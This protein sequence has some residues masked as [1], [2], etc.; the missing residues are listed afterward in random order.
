MR[1]SMRTRTMTK[2]K[3]NQTTISNKDIKD[4]TNVLILAKYGPEM[5]SFVIEYWNKTPEEREEVNEKARRFC[6]AVYE[7]ISLYFKSSESQKEAIVAEL[8]KLA[9]QQAVA[10][11][12]EILGINTPDISN[13]MKFENPYQYSEDR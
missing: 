6:E 8:T 4:I 7:V 1:K 11:L 12:H 10:E 2:T 5:I 9:K 3:N 13:E